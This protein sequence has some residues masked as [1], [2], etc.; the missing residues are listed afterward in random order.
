MV[1][2]ELLNLIAPRS[3]RQG[4]QS[5]VNACKG[6]IDHNVNSLGLPVISWMDAGMA[7]SECVMR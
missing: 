6:K 1:S 4:S 7:G 2:P 3:D 5:T